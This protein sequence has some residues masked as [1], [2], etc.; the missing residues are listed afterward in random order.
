MGLNIE[1]QCLPHYTWTPLSALN[2]AQLSMKLIFEVRITK[3]RTCKHIS[4]ADFD[5]KLFTAITPFSPAAIRFIGNHPIVANYLTNNGNPPIAS[6]LTYVYDK[7]RNN[8][9]ALLYPYNI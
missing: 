3:G 4:L 7:F 1:L 2:Q 8:Q 5:Q 9:Y 6:M